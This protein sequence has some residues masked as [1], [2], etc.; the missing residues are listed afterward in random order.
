MNVTHTVLEGWIEQ[1]LT[2]CGVSKSD[3]RTTA[4]VLTTTNLRGTRTIRL[5]A[6]A[7][8]Q[9]LIAFDLCEIDILASAANTACTIVMPLTTGVQWF[10]SADYVN[11]PEG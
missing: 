9:G 3:A 1:I 6:D 2:A 8:A 4:E 11:L 7:A 10:A 5:P